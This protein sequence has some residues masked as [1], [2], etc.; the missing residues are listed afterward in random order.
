[1]GKI[2]KVGVVRG[3][4]E[5]T[6][7]TSETPDVES[8]VEE[9][10]LEADDNAQDRV[11]VYHSSGTIASVPGQDTGTFTGQVELR[12]NTGGTA[13]DEFV[14]LILQICR[15][16]KVAAVYSPES[17]V[18]SQQT[19]TIYYWQQGKR[20]GLF[21]AH[22]NCKFTAESGGRIMVE[23]ELS[24]KWLAPVDEAQPVP[25][26]NDALPMLAKSCVLTMQT[27]AAKVANFE[28]DM[29]VTVS[30]R[31]DVTDATGVLHYFGSDGAPTFVA[32]PEATTIA[33]HDWDGIRLAST[34]AALSLAMTDGTVTLTLAAPL[35]QYR[36][37][38][39]GD[40]EGMITH[41][42]NCQLNV[43][44]AVDSDWTLT[45]T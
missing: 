36:T 15:S 32:D 28:F 43:G 14:D 6:S 26:H 40:R 39:D 10:A 45:V 20:K 41:D 37:V 11:P 18:A 2:T 42:V 29:G 19:A 25:S 31:E 12:A 35:A 17:A 34:E 24:G 5:G 1:M 27:F 13:L 23:F 9:P 4:L 16:K 33:A 38:A 7:G 22:G 30:P 8:L 21:G 3:K 44:A